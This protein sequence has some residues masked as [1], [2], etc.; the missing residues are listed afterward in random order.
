MTFVFLHE[1]NS[2]N[3]ASL[4]S[5][6]HNNKDEEKTI[7]AYSHSGIHIS[8][9]T[10]LY[11]CP[12]LSIFCSIPS[13]CCILISHLSAMPVSSAPV[14]SAKGH[15]GPPSRVHTFSREINGLSL[16]LL[17][18]SFFVICQH[19]LGGCLQKVNVPSA[20]YEDCKQDVLFV[21]V[22]SENAKYVMLPVFLEQ[23]AEK[24]AGGAVSTFSACFCVRK[25]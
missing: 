16:Q 10:R 23:R 5:E 13:C 4:N 15:S 19:W 24:G 18:L 1:L 21:L 9:I 14:L 7:A 17:L 2:W 20:S 25:C 11:I 22:N 12:Q 3:P 8:Q 6:K